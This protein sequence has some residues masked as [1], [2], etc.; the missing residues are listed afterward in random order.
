MSS[1]NSK[2]CV[3]IVGCPEGAHIGAFFHHTAREDGLP[4]SIIDTREGYKGNPILRRFNWWLRGRLPNRLHE[5]SRH[6]VE[7]CRAERPDLLLVTGTA[8]VTAEALREIDK[9][10]VRTANYLTDDP[11]NTMVRSHWLLEALPQYDHIFTPRRSNRDDLL[12]L[13]CREV[14]YLPFA[15]EPRFH[16]PPNLSDEER[17]RCQSDIAFVG[18]A[19][20]DRVPIMGRLISEGYHVSLWGDYWRRFPRTRPAAHGHADPVTMRA[21]ISAT[22]VA[23]GLVRR[24]NRDGHAMRSYEVAAIGAPMLVEDT[25]EHRALYGPGNDRVC[26]FQNDAELLE[27][28]RWLVDHPAEGRAMAE[29]VRRHICSDAN[30]YADRFRAILA[31][32]LANS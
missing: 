16:F 18:G 28:T 10:G 3:L 21:V 1:T 12:G 20:R 11:W 19:D 26:Y 8:P 25:P 17:S 24:S 32:S 2:P 13:S 29:R 5:F 14:D 30:T 27:R 22:R 23:L 7:R 6:V 4:G 31:A 9:L 15:Y